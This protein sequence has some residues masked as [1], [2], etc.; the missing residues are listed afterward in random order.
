MAK[1]T[2]KASGAPAPGVA[3]LHGLRRQETKDKNAEIRALREQLAE[4]V[5]AMDRLRAAKVP[6]LKPAPVRTRRKDDLVR[7]AF[8]D[9][10]G[11]KMNRAAV[12]ALLA[13]V[14]RL[15]PDEIILGGD[16]VDCGGFLAQKHVMGYVAE[17]R[18]SYE[19]DVAATNGFL[20]ALAAAAPRAAIE[21]LEGNHEHRVETWCV[22]SGLRHSSDAAL[23][24]EAVGPQR[25]LRLEERGIRWFGQGV[26]HDGLRVPGFIRRGKCFFTHGFTTAKHAASVS[27]GKTAGN[28]VFF[29]THRRQDDS[30]RPLSV[31]DV[32]CWNPGCLC[33]LQPLWNHTRPNDWTHG[34]AVQFVSRS[35]EFLHLN[36]PLINGQSLLTPFFE[37]GKK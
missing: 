29:H 7:L 30:A 10:H 36:I 33:E 22:T 4:T 35:G 23:L 13:D 2:L 11:A 17:T 15:D 19:E 31:G 5:A 34:Y 28:L 8:G 26:F 18:Y 32:G 16:M 3:V 27:Q 21:Y 37:R 6:V 24:L 9:L 12:A 20:D 1:R 14:R 25:M